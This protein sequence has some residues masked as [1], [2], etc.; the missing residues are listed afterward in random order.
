MQQCQFIY[1]TTILTNTRSMQTKHLFQEQQ[2]MPKNF[3]IYHSNDLEVL[4]ELLVYLIARDPL[5]D[6]FAK[7]QIV[8]QSYGMEAWLKQMLAR[9]L[10]VMAN[11]EFSYPASFVWKMFRQCLDQ[12]PAENP[13][14]KE[15]MCWKIMTVLPNLLPRPEFRPLRNYLA[16]DADGIKLHQLAEK[17]A[18]VFDQYLIFRSS[19]INAWDRGI[20]DQPEVSINNAW[21]PILWRSLS[22][23]NAAEL[24]PHGAHLFELLHKALF[25]SGSTGSRLP[26]RILIFGTSALAPDYL[27]VLEK[28]SY[29]S[30]VHLFF[31]N[32]SD[33][34]WV[35]LK[36]DRQIAKRYLQNRQV[37]TFDQD[38]QTISLHPN[39]MPA[40]AQ[41]S[42]NFLLASMG[43]QGKNFF[44]QLLAIDGSR[45][46][47]AF[48]DTENPH[49]MLEF[50][51]S[52]IKSLQDYR[53]GNGK[54]ALPEI[55]PS[56]AVHSCH[57]AT[58]EVEVLHDQLLHMFEEMDDLKPQDIIVMIPDINQ[59]SP[60]IQA[61]FGRFDKADAR[62]IP[63]SIADRSVFQEN[64]ILASFLELLGLPKSRC[65]SSEI[66]AILAVPTIYSQFGLTAPCLL[67]I[68]Q[69]VLDCSIRWGISKDENLAFGLPGLD[70]NHWEFG[71]DR[72][73]AGFAMTEGTGVFENIL[74]YN[75]IDGSQAHIVGKL[76]QFISKITEFRSKL[77]KP[78]PIEEWIAL[79]RDLI[80]TFY[81]SRFAD[82]NDCTET[83]L[84]FLEET[85]V[86]FG[87]T[88]RQAGYTQ[89]IHHALM[90]E[91]LE[92]TLID[93]VNSRQFLSGK[94]SFCEFMPMRA[95]PFRT[96]CL[97]GMNDGVFPR[98]HTEVGFDLIMA[99]PKPGDLSRREEERY[100]FLEA[101]LSAKDRLYMSYIGRSIHDNSAKMPSILV[102]ELIEYCEQRFDSPMVDQCTQKPA[103]PFCSAHPLQPFSKRY[104]RANPNTDANTR[105][106]SYSHE[107]IQK[108]TVKTQNSPVMQENTELIPAPP[109]LISPHQLRQFF[110]NPCRYF[111][112]YQ[113]G[114]Y[115]PTQDD[116]TNDE[117]TFI[118]D[119]LDKYLLRERLLNWF[120]EN[121][122][123]DEFKRIE[124]CRGQV[125]YGVLGK[126]QI[127]AEVGF[128]KNLVNVIKEYKNGEFA[129]VGIHLPMGQG[130]AIVGNIDQLIDNNRLLYRVG[131]IRNI[132]KLNL[133]ID[134][135]LLSLCHTNFQSSIFLGKNGK[136][137]AIET[138]CLPR[139]EKDQ[140]HS[141]LANLVNLFCLGQQ[142]PLP[143]F[144]DFCWN[145]LEK[146]I[147]SA[148]E[149]FYHGD[150]GSGRDGEGS[151]V[152]IH[153]CFPELTEAILLQTK[154]NAELVYG[155]L[156]AV[157]EEQ[158]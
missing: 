9:S 75:E 95:I 77:K 148:S 136:S 34:Y 76:A 33:Q 140:A 45:E 108:S 132:D 52:D 137:D 28:V 42:S 18:N 84:L 49:T 87:E 96:V 128:I 70:A 80:A 1:A 68:R 107:W 135:L 149:R 141:V 74:P 143:F 103:N 92:K 22:H 61:I 38:A 59:Y 151:D 98:N 69:W 82:Q 81:N 104:F 39:A 89:S 122:E 21:Q 10:L 27:S 47:E 119:G 63:H 6:V 5:T 46:V 106:F 155:E 113:L 116:M 110:T 147:A 152:Y 94:V 8:I 150:Y 100:M 11:V 133:L 15:V 88:G 3:T 86:A 91:L 62:Y 134:H 60:F 2:N 139:F 146:D 67:T 26:Q 109:E 53:Q 117:E 65:A 12:V 79:L 16:D 64:P 24:V 99:K 78:K 17:I 7:E 114:I 97:L 55:D 121:N 32:P 102:S 30:A 131:S 153:R 126:F 93:T 105:Y 130:T 58:R 71:L 154:T 158:T 35:D 14:N 51:Q 37:A 124:R 111:F 145:L 115:F 118:L 40:H 120:A 44:N 72:M 13:L 144:P 73:L 123:I 156:R 29:F 66:M 138:M 129:V 19:M 4:K 127:D 112:N 85:L 41:A 20:D 48:V 101:V 50:I 142:Q 36:S 54:I 125:G 90:V 31:L 157:L 43:S 23:N 56:I 57:S 25:P 83:T